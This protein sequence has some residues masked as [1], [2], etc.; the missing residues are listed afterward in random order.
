M[1]AHCRFVAGLLLAYGKRLAGF[2]E[3]YRW[4]TEPTSQIY[5]RRLAVGL[6]ETYCTLMAGLL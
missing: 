2:L 6:L 3:V 5:S 1:H 4:L